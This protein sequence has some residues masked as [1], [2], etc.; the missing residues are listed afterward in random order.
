VPTSTA[1][2]TTKNRH[3]R[4]IR[5]RNRTFRDTFANIGPNR[6]MAKPVRPA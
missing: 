1:A 2:K 4:N 3:S 5:R 6:A